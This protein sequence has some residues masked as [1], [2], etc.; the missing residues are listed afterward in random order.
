[1]NKIK[2]IREEIDLVK[3][4]TDKLTADIESDLWSISPKL[5]NTNLN[6]QIGHIFLANYL[7]GIASITGINEEVR[8]MIN[9]QDYIR[10]Y[11]MNS[12]PIENIKEKPSKDELIKLYEFGFKLIS[13]GLDN[14]DES[15]L[16]KSTEIPNPA[17][18]T[19]YQALMWLFK[20]QSWHNGQIAML[21]RI[22][23]EKRV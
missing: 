18:K 7:H 6:W 20:H 5:I 16:N 8:N 23:N 22:L 14:L 2:L 15:D 21:K 10:F 9:I 19:K 12:N 3:S 13:K 1:M 17:V 4:Q 11:G